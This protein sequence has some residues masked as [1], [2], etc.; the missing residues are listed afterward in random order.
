MV[1]D[2]TFPI[3]DEAG[4]PIKGNVISRTVERATPTPGAFGVG[5]V[6]REKDL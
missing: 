4:F 3:D 5:V 2:I 1:S 6:K